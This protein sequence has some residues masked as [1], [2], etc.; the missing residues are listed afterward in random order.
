MNWTKWAKRMNLEF[1]ENCIYSIKLRKEEKF[2]C[3][4]SSSFQECGNCLIKY[5]EHSNWKPL[6]GGD[7]YDLFICPTLKMRVH[8]YNAQETQKGS[9][10]FSC[11]HIL[12]AFTE[13]TA[14]SK[15]EERIESGEVDEKQGVGNLILFDLWPNP[16]RKAENAPEFKADFCQ[17]ICE[18]ASEDKLA[19]EI[20]DEKHDS[21]QEALSKL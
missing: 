21:I 20:S 8:A 9:G 5:D 10:S 6:V 1:R 15:I 14:K 7:V 19:L 12:S 4:W 18:F 16:V 2:G 17:R 3:L 13:L 11:G